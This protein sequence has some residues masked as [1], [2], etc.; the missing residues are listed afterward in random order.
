MPLFIDGTN[1][2]TFPAGGIGNPSSA[3]VGISDSQ[4]LSNKTISGRVSKGNMPAGTVLQVVAARNGDFYSTTSTSWTDITGLSLNITPYSST[5]I[6]W[7]QLSMGRAVTANQN[8]TDICCAIRILANG[9]TSVAINGNQPG[10]KQLIA[11]NTQGLSYNSD[12]N[13]G[14]WTTSAIDSP[15]TTSQIT[16]K[17]QVQCQAQTFVMNTSPNNTN[18]SGIYHG[19]AQS[20]LIAMEI[21]Q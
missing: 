4:T 21:A 5:S 1:G 3:V 17:V 16:Y 8:N 15:A 20:S 9:S 18:D 2:I 12:H 19:Q 10:S 14:G 7:L 13:L 11:M 6:I